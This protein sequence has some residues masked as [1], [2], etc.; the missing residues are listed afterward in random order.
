MIPLLT[1]RT[2][3]TEESP[4]PKILFGDFREKPEFRKKYLP[5]AVSAR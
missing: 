3:Y 1:E 4:L 5:L 2:E